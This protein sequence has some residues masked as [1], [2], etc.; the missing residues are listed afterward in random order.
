MKKERKEPVLGWIDPETGEVFEPG[1][2][3][4]LGQEVVDPRPVE[5]PVGYDAPE[6]LEQR[7]ARL[8]QTEISE[9]AQREGYESFD[10]ANDFDVDDPD[11]SDDIRTPY[12]MEYDDVLGEEV[13][14]AMISENPDEYREKFIKA[15]VDHPEVVE[16]AEKKKFRFPFGSQK[17][18]S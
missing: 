15:G 14:P 12:E 18:R 3:N 13:S 7:I 9:I 5:V 17:G 11:F 2:I 6:P 8:V 16:E 1:R 4:P 10:D